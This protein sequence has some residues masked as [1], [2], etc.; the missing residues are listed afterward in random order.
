MANRFLAGLVLLALSLAPTAAAE[1]IAVA[2]SIKGAI[3]P[4]TSDYIGRGLEEA[5]GQGAVLVVLAM[6]T[7]GGLDS[8]MRDIIKDIL[9]S[10]IPV[11]AYVTPSG[12]RAASAGTYILYASHVA[13]M[14]P[15]TNL[16]AATPIQ[17]GGT[18]FP[19]PGGPGGKP[20]AD[21][22]GEPA[23]KEEPAPRHPELADKAVSDAA[24]YIRSLAQLRGRNADW[25]ERAVREAA[26]LSAADALGDNVIDL[27]AG[28]LGDLMAKLD[29]RAVAIGEGTQ[30]LETAGV[31]V[32]ALEPDW[33]T[34]FLAILTDPNIAYIL[35]LL[36]VYGLIFEFSHPGAVLPGVA[37]G[38][39]LLLALFALHLL[40]INF[41]GLGLLLL[42]VA[43]MV[44]EAFVAGFGVLGFGGVIAFAI[45]SVMLFDTGAGGLAVSWPVVLALTLTS[46]LFFMMVLSMAMK[47]RR[48]PVVS[49]R[50]EMVGSVGRVIAW[51]GREGRV[52]AH[53]EVWRAS[54]ERALAP[55][56]DVR[57]TAVSGLTLVV[58]PL[59]QREGK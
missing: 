48:R 26:S 47:A 6:D 19:F 50:E 56:D 2:L 1:R 11:V 57:V 10:P 7:P 3:G 12:A 30:R 21:K 4:A 27:M 33:R 42:G 41:A 14:A 54:A 43:L 39:S 55:G 25:A 20:P 52:Q 24:A 46:A 22:D 35:F 40:P 45:G 5:R 44:S 37:G 29:G 59:S 38:I 13:A 53:G 18:P 9:A 15:G 58:R 31:S 51:G 8:A 49:G 28:D 36:G 17:L 23:K 34:T 32:V 16:G